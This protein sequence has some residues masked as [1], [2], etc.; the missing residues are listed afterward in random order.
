MAYLSAKVSSIDGKANGPSGPAL[1]FR[2]GVGWLDGIKKKNRNACIY[3][4]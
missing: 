4:R 1:D 2:L 3:K